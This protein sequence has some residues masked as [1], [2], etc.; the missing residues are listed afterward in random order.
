M[1]NMKSKE[2]LIL[3]GEEY[4]YENKSLFKLLFANCIEIELCDL[5]GTNNWLY[6][7]KFF[8]CEN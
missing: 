3:A 2:K 5:T 1:K 6:H 4:Q 8:C 7:K